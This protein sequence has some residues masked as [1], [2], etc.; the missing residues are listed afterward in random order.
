MYAYLGNIGT[1]HALKKNAGG[2]GV[3]SETNVGLT[4]VKSLIFL[5]IA[6]G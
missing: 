5:Y 4:T 3:D 2:G 1:F 6:F